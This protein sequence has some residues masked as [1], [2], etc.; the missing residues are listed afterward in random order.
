MALME[1]GGVSQVQESENAEG[2][3]QTESLIWNYFKFVRVQ[4]R[5]GEAKNV[6]CTLCDKALTGCS[7]S[8]ALA[9]ILGR[10]VLGK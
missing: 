4:R 2:A 5:N 8:R 3:E 1:N 6:T 9:H 10:A 7:S